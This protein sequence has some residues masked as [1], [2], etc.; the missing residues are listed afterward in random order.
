ML[1]DFVIAAID[2]LR[3]ALEPDEQPRDPEDV[4]PE[5]DD[6]G[7][8]TVG[9]WAGAASMASASAIRRDIAFAKS[10][11]LRRIDIIVNDHAAERLPAK[12]TS[13]DLDKVTALADA[14][15]AAGLE[16][17]LM[18]WLMP[19]TPYIDRAADIL[20]PLVR[21]CRAKSIVWDCEEPWTLA[22]NQLPHAAAAEIV[23]DRFVGVPCGVTGIG[24]APTEKLAPICAV[25]E[26]IVPQCYSTASSGLNPGTVVPKFAARWRK[27]FP[28][29]PLA[30]GLAAYRQSGI[31]GYTPE[32]ALRAASAGAEADPQ[33]TTAI[34][35]SL[36]QIRQSSIATRVLRD[37]TRRG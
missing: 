24:Y 7:I 1:P 11:G 34:Y 28:G 8:T 16:V 35:W 27:V 15:G 6:I 26:Y 33:A 23:A 5:P 37:L 10:I 31:P 9:A 36:G 4:T 19:S 12:F 13:Y 30:I 20:L 18:S 17:H 22:R 2:S 25:A 29:K 32:A 21:R 3:R 14:A